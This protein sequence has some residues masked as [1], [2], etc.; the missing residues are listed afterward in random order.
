MGFEN[1]SVGI[2]PDK[3]L[4]ERF[5]QAENFT[6]SINMGKIEWLLNNIH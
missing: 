2:L 1:N 4:D 3:L 6:S 5:L